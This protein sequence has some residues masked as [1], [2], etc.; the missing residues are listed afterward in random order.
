MAL[1]KFTL[2]LHLP[3]TAYTRLKAFVAAVAGAGYMEFSYGNLSALS[4]DIRR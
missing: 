4:R 1:K 2:L 3:K